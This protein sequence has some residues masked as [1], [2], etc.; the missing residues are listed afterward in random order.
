MRRQRAGRDAGQGGSI[1]SSRPQPSGARC[2]RLVPSPRRGQPHSVM[3]VSVW[4]D[5]DV[6]LPAC[7]R[8]CRG[9]AQRRC[10]AHSLPSRA[11][12]PL[13][14]ELRRRAASGMRSRARHR[15]A[16][17]AH[18]SAYQCP[19]PFSR[20]PNADLPAPCKPSA[21]QCASTLWSSAHLPS[22]SPSSPL[23]AERSLRVASRAL[24]RTAPHPRAR[25][26]ASD[27]CA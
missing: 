3:I 27:H 26:A 11:R 20:N 24:S 21:P 2:L 25:S 19:L 15:T 6:E 14:P 10:G 18:R 23:P 17:H 1:S 16:Q 12:S 8:E 4:I 13:V 5:G 22:S 9:A 7:A